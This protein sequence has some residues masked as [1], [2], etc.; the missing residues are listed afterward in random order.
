MAPAGPS[1]LGE[2]VKSLDR[3]KGLA[4][5]TEGLLNYFPRDQVQTLWSV[6]AQALHAFP[7]GIYL[8]DLHLRAQNLGLSTDL[9]RKLLARFV[10]GGVHL[11]YANEADAERALLEAGF[12]NAK[13]HKAEPQANKQGLIDER[14]AGL[15][16]IIEARTPR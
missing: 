14:G 12:S 16:R 10:R 13:L 7:Q 9:F 11:H 5:V 4:I 8:S 1:S 6:F 15:V 3:E 2:V